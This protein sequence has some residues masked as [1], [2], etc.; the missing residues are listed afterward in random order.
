M[1]WKLK[2]QR[3]MTL[4]SSEVEYVALLEAAKEIKFI[5]QLLQ[6]IGVEIELPIVVR[7]DNVG[8]LHEQE[9]VN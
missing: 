9:Y 1:T 7:V 5:Y 4:S 3:S 2:S 8:H 6:S